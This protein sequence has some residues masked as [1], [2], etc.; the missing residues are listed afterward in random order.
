MAVARDDLGRAAWKRGIEG[1]VTTT[2]HFGIRFI[3]GCLEESVASQKG[4]AN[5]TS[6]FPDF[7]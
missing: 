7:L 1:Q 6:P 4:N 5:H 2:R 3:G